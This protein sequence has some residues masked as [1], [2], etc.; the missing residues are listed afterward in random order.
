MKVD[1]LIHFQKHYDSFNPL[2]CCNSDFFLCESVNSLPQ[3]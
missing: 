1:S 3:I 2:Q